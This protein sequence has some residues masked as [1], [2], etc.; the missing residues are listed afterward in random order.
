MVKK[1]NQKKAY[2]YASL[3]VFFWSTVATAFK[4]TLRYTGYIELLMF[5]TLFS[6]IALFILSSI[7]G[8]LNILKSFTKSDILYASFMGFLNPFLYYFLIFKAYSMLPAQL[9]QPLNQ[10]WGIVI[11]L[12]SVL[13]LK[14]KIGL[15]SIIGVLIGFF[16]VIILSTRG[17]LFSFKIEQP[18]GVFLA[19]LSSV[20]WSFYW[21]LNVKRGKDPL[22]SL[23]INFGFGLIY[24]SV[25]FFIFYDPIRISMEALAGTLYIGLFEMGITFIFWL[26]ALKYSSRIANVS[27]LIYLAPFLSLVFINY[28]L[29]EKIMVSSFLGLIFIV[30][31]IMLSRN[32][33]VGN[34]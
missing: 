34:I 5:S 6:F 33:N 32:D 4:L 9:A 27:I 17:E 3:S 2:I 16:G 18:L 30:F 31:G 14:Q 19:L 29:D 25:Y 8:K 20:V 23:L 7:R 26:K 24:I 28:I 11:V 10:I 12:M 22:I 13:L 21:I 1:K 15:R